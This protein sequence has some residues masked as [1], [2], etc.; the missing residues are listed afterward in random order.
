MRNKKIYNKRKNSYLCFIYEYK[1]PLRSITDVLMEVKRSKDNYIEY[2]DIQINQ[3]SFPIP[4]C[5][6][7]ASSSILTKKN[8]VKNILFVLSI[9]T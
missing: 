9:A 7:F 5:V 6:C 3:R 2:M 1:Y 4:L 8:I